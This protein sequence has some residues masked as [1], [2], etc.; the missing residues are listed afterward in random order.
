MWM[1]PHCC[2]GGGG[3]LRRQQQQQQQYRETGETATAAGR[4]GGSSSRC[5]KVIKPD[6]WRMMMD[7]LKRRTLNMSQNHHVHLM[8][9]RQT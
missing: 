8:R 4:G 2:G 5:G 3:Q 7:I 1:L 9:S 6:I